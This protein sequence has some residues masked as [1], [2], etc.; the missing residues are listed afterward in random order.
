MTLT[1]TIFYNNFMIDS[2]HKGVHG[3]YYVRFKGDH[4]DTEF[5]IGGETRKNNIGNLLII[6]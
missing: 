6:I 4:Q 1:I 2:R 5:N 3:M